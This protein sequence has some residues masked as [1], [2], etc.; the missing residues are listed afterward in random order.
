MAYTSTKEKILSLPNHGQ[1]YV[2]NGCWTGEMV[3]KDDEKYILVV[4]TGSLN[5]V[6]DRANEL[7]DLD[8]VVKEEEWKALNDSYL[9]GADS[10]CAHDVQPQPGGGIKCEKCDGW[11][12]E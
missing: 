4:E 8:I 7:D 9:Y 11:Y 6:S 5:K 1:F 12:C 10:N 2:I 3:E